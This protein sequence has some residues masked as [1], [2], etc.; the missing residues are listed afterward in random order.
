[1]ID[2]TKYKYSYPVKA[3]FLGA[4]ISLQDSKNRVILRPEPYEGGT[5]GRERMYAIFNEIADIFNKQH[6]MTSEFTIGKLENEGV[7]QVEESG[8]ETERQEVLIR[9]RG[10]PKKK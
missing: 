8:Q 2:L 3:V 10:R 4:N 5:Y 7:I 1:M 6:R 9:G